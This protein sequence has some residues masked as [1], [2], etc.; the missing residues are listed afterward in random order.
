MLRGGNGAQ[1]A[2]LG[3][4]GQPS[5]AMKR[6][7]PLESWMMTSDL[8]FAAASITALMLSLPTTFTAGRA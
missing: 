4:V 1:D 3:G 5:P 6:A 8:F 2:R 7:P